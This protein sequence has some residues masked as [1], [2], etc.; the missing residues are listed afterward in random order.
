MLIVFVII[1]IATGLFMYSACY[2][3]SESDRQNEALFA[4]WSALHEK[5]GED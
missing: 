4:E 3:A 1:F 5:D 2:V